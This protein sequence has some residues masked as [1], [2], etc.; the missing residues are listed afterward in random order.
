MTKR[1]RFRS[2][3]TNSY[4]ADQ[5]VEDSANSVTHSYEIHKSFHDACRKELLVALVDPNSHRWQESS[6]RCEARYNDIV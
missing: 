5:T 2:P 1:N 6:V 3:Q 4:E